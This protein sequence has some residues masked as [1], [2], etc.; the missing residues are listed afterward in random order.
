MKYIDTADTRVA[1]KPEPIP[2][3]MIA[4]K[5]IIAPK[6]AMRTSQPLSNIPKAINPCPIAMSVTM[7]I[8][9][10]LNHPLIKSR[11]GSKG[12]STA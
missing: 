8:I 9:F 6:Q 12:V 2:S 1:G 5:K 10:I 11:Y 3:G 4:K 7:G